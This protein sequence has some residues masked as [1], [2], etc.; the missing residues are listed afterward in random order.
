MNV[1]FL[2]LYPLH[3]LSVIEPCCETET[4]AAL[5]WAV[6]INIGSAYIRLVSIPVDIPFELPAGLFESGL[7]KVL[8]EGV[9]AAI[10]GCVPVLLAEA[11]RA[12]EKLAGSGIYAKDISLPCLNGVTVV[13]LEKTLL[14]IS[15]AVCL[16]NHYEIGG[17]GDML[18]RE[19]QKPA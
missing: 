3:G 19:S 5:D 9:D 12:A 13:W 18:C 11:W 15:A 4:R 2:G 6:D 16:A 10:V 17:Q 7:G 1:L 14:G 8:C